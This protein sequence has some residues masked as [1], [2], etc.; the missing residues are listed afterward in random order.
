MDFHFAYGSA[1]ARK[2]RIYLAEKG[3]EATEHPKHRGFLSVEEIA[4]LNPNLTIPVMFDGEVK[5]FD[6][7]VMVAYILNKYPSAIDANP[8]LL[9]TLVRPECKWRDLNLLATLQTLSTSLEHIHCLDMIDGLTGETVSYLK[10][11]H[12]RVNSI[13][14]WLDSQASPKGF[15]PGWFSLMDITFIVQMD[16]S[17]TR[18]GLAWRGRENLNQLYAAFAERPSV[19]QTRYPWMTAAA[20]ADPEGR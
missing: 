5:M 2:V 12:T 16:F 9:P 4:P 8:P 19:V 18:N 17:E 7:Q 14:D 3:A 15:A 20:D 1:A 11:E 6:S 10:R 13:L